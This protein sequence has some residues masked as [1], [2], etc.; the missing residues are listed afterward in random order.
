MTDT[1]W[2]TCTSK[3]GLLYPPWWL[4][5]TS[6]I[7]AGEQ[8]ALTTVLTTETAVVKHSPKATSPKPQA[9]VWNWL[10]LKQKTLAAREPCKEG[11]RASDVFISLSVFSRTRWTLIR[12]WNPAE[13]NILI[14]SDLQSLHVFILP[15]PHPQFQNQRKPRV[16]PVIFVNTFCH[17]N[18]L[19][20]KH[21]SF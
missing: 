12:G 3:I 19:K 4:P 11:R 17:L 13:L 6:A 20:T 5:G 21:T 15:L 18:I 14:Y 2:P 8:S 9:R 7:P 10:G 16:L 1:E